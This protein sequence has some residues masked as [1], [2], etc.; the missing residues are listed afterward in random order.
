MLLIVFIYAYKYVFA[1]SLLLNVTTSFCH[2]AEIS[3]TKNANVFI[4]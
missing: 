4:L 2:P 3:A 1:S